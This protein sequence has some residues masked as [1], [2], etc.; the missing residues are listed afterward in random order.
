M[1]EDDLE[2]FLRGEAWPSKKGIK[3]RDISVYKRK[4]NIF[5]T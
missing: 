3:G 1:I 4:T 2:F 5:Y